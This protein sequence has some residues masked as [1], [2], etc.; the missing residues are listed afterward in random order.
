[1]RF[2]SP[3]VLALLPLCLL[4]VL[5]RVRGWFWPAR[6]LLEERETAAG[7][8]RWLIG[9]C[10][11]VALALAILALA[12]PGP[13]GEAERPAPPVR[14]VF[15]LLDTSRSMDEKDFPTRAGATVRRIEAAKAVVAAFVGGA[16]RDRVGVIAFGTRAWTVCPLTSDHVVAERLLGGVATGES[17]EKTAIGDALALALARL[18]P[19]GYRS[20]AVVLVTDGRNTAGAAEPRQVAL[21]AAR[22]GV[23]I[24]CVGIGREGEA[25]VEEGVNMALLSDLARRTGGAAELAA[26]AGSLERIF[27]AI[28]RIRPEAE[29]GAAGPVPSWS[30][31]LA[32]AACGALLAGLLLAA[33][34]GR[35]VPY[36]M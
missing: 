26:D 20:A 22:R 24:E 15:V 25:G 33:G 28:G 19:R 6:R 36:G 2:E 35:T 14:N 10:R 16:G 3:W 5:G 17:G 13:S 29:A 31:P 4:P 27:A 21:L 18:E 34:P 30:G 8:V 11:V 7:P 23:R 1:M 32:L 9:A 12:G